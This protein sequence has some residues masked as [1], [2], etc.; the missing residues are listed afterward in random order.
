MMFVGAKLKESLEITT[1]T[2]L[3]NLLSLPPYLS[4][5]IQN[6][7]KMFHL[8]SGLGKNYIYN[9]IL[10]DTSLCPDFRNVMSCHI[11]D[12]HIRALLFIKVPTKYYCQTSTLSSFATPEGLESTYAAG[13]F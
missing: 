9:N 12:G 13:T 6:N 4:K 1:A 5:I 3:K 8:F 11:S 10:T 7:L 2:P